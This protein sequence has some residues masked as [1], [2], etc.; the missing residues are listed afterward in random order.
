MLSLVEHT[1]T[2]TT[3]SSHLCVLYPWLWQWLSISAFLAIVLKY[4]IFKSC[5]CDTFKIFYFLYEEGYILGRLPHRKLVIKTRPFH[6]DV[7]LKSPSNGIVGYLQNCILLC[8]NMQDV[9]TWQAPSLVSK[10]AVL[11]KFSHKTQ[12]FLHLS[13]NL[14][15]NSSQV[16]QRSSSWGQTIPM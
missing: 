14:Q 10:V 12:H 2:N 7:L 9:K 5:F 13:S 1:N 6:W 15:K 3:F 8:F 11:Q 16:A 4:S